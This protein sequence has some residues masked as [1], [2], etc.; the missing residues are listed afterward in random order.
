MRVRKTGGAK[1]GR[2]LFKVSVN[3]DVSMTRQ[4]LHGLGCRDCVWE[5]DSVDC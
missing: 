2:V 5:A 4:Y 1:A 3:H